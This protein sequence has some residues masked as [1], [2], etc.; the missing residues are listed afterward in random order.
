[1]EVFEGEMCQ[2]VS[3]NFYFI[4]LLKATKW[5]SVLNKKYKKRYKKAKYEK[6]SP[7]IDF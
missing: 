5:Q 1:M 3:P 7:N 6:F 4:K 2:S